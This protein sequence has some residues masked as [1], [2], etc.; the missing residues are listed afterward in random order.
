MDGTIPGIIDGRGGQ[1]MHAILIVSIALLALV[2]VFWLIKGRRPGRPAGGANVQR[3]AVVGSTAIDTRR[4]L[5]LVRRDDVEHLILIGGPADLVVESAISPVERDTVGRRERAD[6]M[7][8]EPY[9]ATENP[10]RAAAAAAPVEPTLHAPVQPQRAA[11]EPFAAER[12][13]ENPAPA[14]VAAGNPFGDAD[15]GAVLEEEMARRDA[16]GGQQPFRE[17][18]QQPVRRETQSEPTTEEEM[19]RLL[20]DMSRNRR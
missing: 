16:D 14:G 8:S 17:P 13:R 6:S 18:E 11:A 9:L 15:F 2:V 10:P 4:R 3:L 20:A 5:V 19:A 7:G 12:F 1:M